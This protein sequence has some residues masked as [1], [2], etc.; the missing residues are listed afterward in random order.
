MYQKLTEGQIELLRPIM[1]KLD[2]LPEGGGVTVSLSRGSLEHVRNLLY[3]R[4]AREGLRGVFRISREGSTGLRIV[5]R[6]TAEVVIKEDEPPEALWETF[7]LQQCIEDEQESEV[8]RKAGEAGFGPIE[9]AKA[10]G[11]WRRLV[12]KE[13]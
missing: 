6:E 11:F 3:A 10:V 13:G 1:E 5:R 9:I 8:E 2:S 4:L 12:G 7:V